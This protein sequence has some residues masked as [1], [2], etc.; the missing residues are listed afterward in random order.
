MDDYKI[1]NYK[2][3]LV[4]MLKKFW[5]IVLSALVFGVVAFYITTYA[6]MPMYTATIRLY[7]NN[8]T[9]ASNSLTSSDL[10]AAKSLVDTAI[11][12][13]QSDSV[14]GKITEKTKYGYN[15][16]Q[17]K[18]MMT[19]KSINGTEVFELSITGHSPEEC[20]D[21]ANTIADVAPFKISEIV[22]GSSVKIIDRAK[23]PSVPV[24]PSVPRN[25]AVAVL[26]GIAISGVFLLFLFISD[27]TIYSE[28]DVKELCT[29]PI[30][31]VLPDFAQVSQG[32]SYNSYTYAGRSS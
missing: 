20:A 19:A 8:K 25:V 22:E 32:K 2:S 7:A 26:F 29:L 21:I 28:K 12:I 9:E 10:T 11:S 17:I 27:T 15:N 6:I 16:E 13:I 14:I 31:G 23:I 4:Y 5:V 18:N 24:S 30:L 3:L 1:I